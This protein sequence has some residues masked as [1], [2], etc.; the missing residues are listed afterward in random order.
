MENFLKAK[1][2]RLIYQTRAKALVFVTKRLKLYFLIKT[3]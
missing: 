3:T 1:I 2:L